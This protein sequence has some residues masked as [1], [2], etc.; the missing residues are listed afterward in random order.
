M[1]IGG[2]GTSFQDRASHR[3][4]DLPTFAISGHCWPQGNR[5]F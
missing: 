5:S 2:E 4:Y 3:E 1:E